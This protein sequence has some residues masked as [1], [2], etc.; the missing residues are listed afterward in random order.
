[1]TGFFELM[2]GY[3]IYLAE[4]PVVLAII[5]MFVYI[6]YSLSLFRKQ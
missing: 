6:M 5:L 2:Q 3:F 1:M 4:V